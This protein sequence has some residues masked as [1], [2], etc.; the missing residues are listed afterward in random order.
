MAG[1]CSLYS[2]DCAVEV[3]ASCGFAYCLA[4][5][6][7]VQ[8]VP[9]PVIEINQLSAVFVTSAVV[10]SIYIYPI[11]IHYLLISIIAFPSTYQ[12]Y[13]LKGQIDK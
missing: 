10:G 2:L 7:T 6:V 5:P 8:V 1:L 4:L 11:S 9:L 3:L 13:Q 12:K